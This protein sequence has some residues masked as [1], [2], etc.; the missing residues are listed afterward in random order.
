MTILQ[1]FLLNNYIWVNYSFFLF[2]LL[3]LQMILSIHNPTQEIS[4]F[5]PGWLIPPKVLDFQGKIA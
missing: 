1:K 3:Y 2:Y 4:N 5:Y